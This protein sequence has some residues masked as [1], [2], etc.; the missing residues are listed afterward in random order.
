M[1]KEGLGE[2]FFWNL[3]W[4]SESD[5]NQHE[6]KKKKSFKMLGNYYTFWSPTEA[7]AHYSKY[8]P[9]CYVMCSYGMTEPITW[10]LAELLSQRLSSGWLKH[11]ALHPSPFY[12]LGSVH[13]KAFFV[14]RGPIFVF[15]FLALGLTHG[16]FSCFHLHD[17]HSLVSL[18]GHS[19]LGWLSWMV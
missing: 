8:Q 17:A 5:S 11:H 12:H 14:L 16:M 1:E 15:Y 19:E 18:N 13:C 10:H 6:K 9:I 3:P 7:L 4:M 2:R